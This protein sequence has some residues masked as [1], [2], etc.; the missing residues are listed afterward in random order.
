MKG[1]A[2][3]DIAPPADDPLGVLTTTAPVVRAARLVA[4]DAARVAAL[5]QA[6]AGGAWPEQEGLDALHWSDGT[7]RTANWMLLADA[8]NFCFWGEVGAPRWRVAWQGATYDGYYALVAALSR[9][10]AEG[11]PLWDAA[12]LADLGAGELAH[13]LRPVPGAP[14]IPLFAERL[15]NARE[16]GHVLHAH[17][18]GQFAHAIAAADYDAV[19]L[20]QLLARDFPSFNDVAA[21]RGATVRFY[22][23]A[24]IC[25][26][27]LHA[28]FRGAGWGAIRGLERLTA[29]AD[30]KLPQLLRQH[31]VLRYAPEMA[32]L[33]DSYTLIP[34]GAEAEVEIRAATI[35]AVEL[36]RQA[37]A[38]RGVVRTAS[39]IDYRLWLESQQPGPQ[40]RPYHR[41]RTIYY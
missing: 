35:W 15:A 28:I 26:A 8:L 38:A 39:A 36:L 18:D 31:G 12:Y 40:A 22:K 14:P 13:I 41:T 23:R 16:V 25:V 7:E 10:V 37:L 21:W 5:A 24:Q 29:F 34:A 20:A 2:E 6:W 17:Y 4:I 19:R 32:A 33:V 30:Y 11:C 9:A 3:L 1:E 27:D